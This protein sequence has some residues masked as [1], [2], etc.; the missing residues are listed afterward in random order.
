MI[1]LFLAMNDRSIRFSN[2]IA[3]KKGEGLISSD[4]S[5]GIGCNPY[6]VAEPYGRVRTSPPGY[7]LSSVS[8]T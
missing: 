3:N 8:T 6:V 2:K 5:D 1:R 4:P 7:D